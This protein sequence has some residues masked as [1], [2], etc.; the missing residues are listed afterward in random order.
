MLIQPPIANMSNRNNYCQISNTD[1]R[2]PQ[3]FLPT[4]LNFTR[5]D[6]IKWTNHAY[7]SWDG[8]STLLEATE[9]RNHGLSR[10]NITVCFPSRMA[11]H[12]SKLKKEK[13]KYIRKYKQ[14]ATDIQQWCVVQTPNEYTEAAI[15]NW[16]LTCDKL[17]DDRD[18]NYQRDWPLAAFLPRYI[19][20]INKA[21]QNFFD[22]IT[23]IYLNRT[24]YWE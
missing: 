21:C 7:T 17:M 20:S 10:D 11:K 19:Y 1:L 8:T 24:V 4:S 18:F 14:T 22:T 13:K 12:E 5:E 15:K 9:T 2:N 23:R 6:K 16:K 3:C